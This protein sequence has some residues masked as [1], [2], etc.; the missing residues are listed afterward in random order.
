M[1]AEAFR[2]VPVVAGIALL[3]KDSDGDKRTL[4]R[5]PIAV[6]GVDPRPYLIGGAHPLINVPL[7]QDT[8]SG[9]GVITYNPEFDGI[10]RR[11]PAVVRVGGEIY[12]ALAIELIRIATGGRTLVVKT[13]ADG[14]ESIVLAGV[15]APN[16]EVPHGSPRADLGPFLAIGP[17]ALRVRAR[18]IGGPGRSGQARRSSRPRRHVG[19]G[20][21]RHKGDVRSSARCPE[22]RFTRN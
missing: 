8:A 17:G 18:R 10:V 6:L 9:T 7:L 14:V 20:I 5:P 4:K 2:K 11:V 16:V 13:G 12:P 1:L 19:G 15:D 3:A 21:A 22:S